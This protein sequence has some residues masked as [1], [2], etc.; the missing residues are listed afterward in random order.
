MNKKEYEY[1][2]F[3]VPAKRPTLND[4]PHKD[5]SHDHYHHTEN[6]NEHLRLTL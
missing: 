5:I 4:L 3:N 1:K 6:I 2:K